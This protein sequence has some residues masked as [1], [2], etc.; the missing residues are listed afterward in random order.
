MKRKRLKGSGAKRGN[1][2]VGFL[3]GGSFFAKG[4]A[5]GEPRKKPGG[6]TGQR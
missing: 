6:G 3:K 2:G 5:G 4:V 1:G